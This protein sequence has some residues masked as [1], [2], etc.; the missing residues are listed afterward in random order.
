MDYW[1]HLPVIR[2][3]PVA[4]RAWAWWLRNGPKRAQGTVGGSAAFRVLSRMSRSEHAYVTLEA[5][6]RAKLTI[7]LRDFESFHH[8]IPV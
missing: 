5:E 2:Q 1:P 4:Y 7:D 3:L 8:A 6:G